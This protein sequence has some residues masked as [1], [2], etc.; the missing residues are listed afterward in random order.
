MCVCDMC[1]T[2]VY[3]TCVYVTCVCP[4]R[5]T[6]GIES[7]GTGVIEGSKGTCVRC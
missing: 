1:V 3:V 4:L 7:P 2:C 5:G 6:E